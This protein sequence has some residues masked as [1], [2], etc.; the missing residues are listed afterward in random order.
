[1]SDIVERGIK[2]IIKAGIEEKFYRGNKFRQLFEDL[3]FLS[4]FYAGWH[5]II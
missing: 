4:S 5:Y 2:K 3:P 1:M